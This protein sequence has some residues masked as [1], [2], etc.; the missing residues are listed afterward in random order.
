VNEVFVIETPERL[1]ALDAYMKANWL[2]AVKRDAP[3]VVTIEDD[4]R[5]RSTIQNRRYWAL[6]RE[7]SEGAR[8]NDKQYGSDTWH[9]FFKAKYIGTEEI[10]LPDRRRIERPISTTALSVSEF[11]EYMTRVEAYAATELNVEFLG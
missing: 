1:R 6:L 3:L 10:E 2:G 4:V 5:Q 9:E 7:I 8:P 11:A